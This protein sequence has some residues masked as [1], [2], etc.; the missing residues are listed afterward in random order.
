MEREGVM[1]RQ[2]DVI[3]DEP[4]HECNSQ[5]LALTPQDPHT[6][7]MSSDALTLVLDLASQQA[8]VG[9]VH[10]Q[11]AT[12]HT[13]ADRTDETSIL[14]AIQTTLTAAGINAPNPL[15]HIERIVLL[16]GPGGFMSLRM[17]AAIVNTLAWGLPCPIAGLHLSDL[18]AA[19]IPPQSTVVWLHSTKR[20][21]LFVRGC[22]AWR[23]RWPDPVLTSMDA[24]LVARDAMKGASYVGD[25]L[26]AH[27][28]M[29]Q[30]PD[31]SFSCKSIED[32]L[33]DITQRLSYGKGP[34]EPWYGREG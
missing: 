9:V 2:R 32:V 31:A 7:T 28:D 19:R 15:R 26:P 13:L 10:H 23:E 20:D 29:V 11:H 30:L 17:G 16:T 24:L 3:F 12:L 21:A 25:L 33:P 6:A 34:I 22:G 27:R 8:W 4:T 18:W 1:Q 5:A 14:P